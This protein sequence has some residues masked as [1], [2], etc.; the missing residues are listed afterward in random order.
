MVFSV[1]NKE[2]IASSVIPR[3]RSSGSSYALLSSSPAATRNISFS[4]SRNC[5]L[6]RVGRSIRCEKIPGQLR[7]VPSTCSSL[8]M[9]TFQAASANPPVV[10]VE[11]ER[12]RGPQQPAERQEQRNF[13]SNRDRGHRLAVRL[14]NT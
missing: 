12:A 8:D 10:T 5:M 11:K 2:L 4:C 9:L 6:L 3:H 7:L 1:K 13:G 14:R